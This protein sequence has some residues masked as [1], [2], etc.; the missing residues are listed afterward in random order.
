MK[1][2]AIGLIIIVIIIGIGKIVKIDN[3]N[4]MKGCLSAGYSET[5]CIA[6]R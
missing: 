6:H 3:D 1:K 5:Y 2:I 4:F